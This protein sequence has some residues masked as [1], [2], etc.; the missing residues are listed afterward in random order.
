MALIGIFLLGFL[1]PL[2]TGHSVAF[3][4]ALSTSLCA[5]AFGTVLWSPFTNSGPVDVTWFMRVR[6]GLDGGDT[7]QK[8]RW[9]VF[10][11]DAA[12]IAEVA[13]WR[14]AAD[15]WVTAGSWNFADTLTVHVGGGVT[16]S[17][18]TYNDDPVF[19]CFLV[20]VRSAYV[21]NA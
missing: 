19:Q 5:N 6:I 20:F 18:L 9:D 8:A 14:G 21:V 2:A 15:D 12:I 17:I 4:T 7:I 13:N 1:L 16:M 11:I 10:I 3:G